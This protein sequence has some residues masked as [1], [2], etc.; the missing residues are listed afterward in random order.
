MASSAHSPMAR[1]GRFI[2]SSRR[3]VC[4][5]KLPWVS[6]W[7]VVKPTAISPLPWPMYDPN[8]AMPT[9]ARRRT[10]FNWRLDSGRSVAAMRMIL[11]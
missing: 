5:W 3:M 1:K 10:R 4:V 8:R 6:I 2:R 9:E 7:A 11:P